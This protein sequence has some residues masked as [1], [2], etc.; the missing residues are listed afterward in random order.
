MTENN[1]DVPLTPTQSDF[2]IFDSLFPGQFLG[3]GFTITTA[4]HVQGFVDCVKLKQ[5]VA[6]VIAAH[7]AF[8]A[9]FVKEGQ[10]LTQRFTEYSE[11]IWIDSTM[12]PRG[13]LS[14]TLVDLYD[15]LS[16]FPLSPFDFPLIAGM[17]AQLDDH[18]FFVGL[19]V[20]HMI[21]DEFSLQRVLNESWKDYFGQE[22]SSTSFS[23]YCLGQADAYGA[24]ADT[25]MVMS[26]WEEMYSSSPNLFFPSSADVSNITGTS[27]LA[28]GLMEKAVAFDASEN[29]V[30]SLGEFR[31]MHNL[32][33]FPLYLTAFVLT[34]AA[35]T[36]SSSDLSVTTIS[37]AGLDEANSEL[38]VGLTMRLY[39]VVVPRSVIEMPILDL[40]K[41]LQKRWLK[42]WKNSVVPLQNIV[43]KHPQA[44]DAFLSRS[45]SSVPVLFQV[46]PTRQADIPD[47][48]LDAQVIH[49]T[50]RQGWQ[51]WGLE[52]DVAIGATNGA[53]EL[54]FDPPLFSGT[55]INSIGLSMLK[56]FE[57]I[58]A[59]AQTKAVDVIP[60]LTN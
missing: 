23:A 45:G 58:P 21:L 8:R 37:H 30:E 20:H 22:I 28:S 24:K 6:R 3:T 16:G 49:S 19:T 48:R 1:M 7:D 25:R 4:M 29:S 42:G 55:M 17:I 11:V 35:F 13:E 59:N 54:H 50:L 32:L 51:S 36:D 40:A 14:Q 26:Y 5:S 57:V 12:E 38:P 18:D 44:A 47:S 31:R 52:I 53:V 56:A 60:M 10:S 15:V 2:A 27:T 34:K 41:Q 33:W 9:Y 43:S 46:L 39:P